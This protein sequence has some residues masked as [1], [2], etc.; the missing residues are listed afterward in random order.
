MASTYPNRYWY[1][2]RR[3]L[4]GL[5]RQRLGP[6]GSLRSNRVPASVFWMAMS[7]IR[8]RLLAMDCR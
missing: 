3:Y 4:F 1:T 2:R 7:L 8:D 6:R 5:G